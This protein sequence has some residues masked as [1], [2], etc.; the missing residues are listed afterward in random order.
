M[1]PMLCPIVT[2]VSRGVPFGDVCAGGDGV[3]VGGKEDVSTQGNILEV[4]PLVYNLQDP[5]GKK[6]TYTRLF[7]I[8]PVWVWG[9]W[10]GRGA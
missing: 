7:T 5:G 2:V 3:E 9:A 10:R 6:H 1:V 4:A 8:H